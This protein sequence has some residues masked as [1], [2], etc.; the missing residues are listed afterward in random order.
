MKIFLYNFY[1]GLQPGTRKFR[2]EPISA[3][4]IYYETVEQ[5]SQTDELYHCLF[6]SLLIVYIGNLS[7][8]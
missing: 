3:C 7:I 6:E 4:C 1:E 8:L 2:Q 5:L